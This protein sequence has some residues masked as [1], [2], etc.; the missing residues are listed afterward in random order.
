LSSP[1]DDQV[2]YLAGDR[3]GLLPPDQRA[4]LDELRALL[5]G[6]AVWVEPPESLAEAVVTAIEREARA[7][8]GSTAVRRSRRWSSRRFSI[9]AVGAVAVAAISVA[10]L[11]VAHGLP[12]ANHIT[13]FAMV[14]SGTA[15][16]PQAH[17]SATL[18]KTA[19]GWQIRLRATGLPH[20][21]DGRY[22]QAWLKNGR[23]VLVPVGTFNDARHV[24]LWSGVPVTQFPTLTVTVQRVGRGPASSGVRVLSGA[25]RR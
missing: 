22:Y 25:I 5:A 18:T 9:A 2:A 4:R 13:R 23:G 14:V 21:A 17:G 12:T 15:L 11:V 20:L 7:P 24:T 8:A 6:A 16:A 19:S 3:P 10:V 1:H